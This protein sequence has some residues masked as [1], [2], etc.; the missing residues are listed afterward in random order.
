MGIL[1]NKEKRYEP[2][3]IEDFDD[4][5]VV[6]EY[7][8]YAFLNIKIYDLSSY[9]F[10]SDFFDSDTETP[11]EDKNNSLPPVEVYRRKK[12]RRFRRNYGPIEIIDG[13]PVKRN[14]GAQ[15]WRRVENGCFHFILKFK[16]QQN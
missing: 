2:I 10:D 11:A 6:N 1:R 3:R 13:L 16:F 12:P 15:K 4:E 7:G 14:M 5:A 8:K 9:L